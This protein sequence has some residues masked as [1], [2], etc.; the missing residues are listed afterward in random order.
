[1]A[2]VQAGSACLVK[3]GT[4]PRPP[5]PSISRP[6]F[7]VTDQL[8]QC[9]ISAHTPTDPSCLLEGCEKH[10]FW[11]LSL[12]LCQVLAVQQGLIFRRI[13]PASPTS[14]VS[15]TAKGSSLG[16]DWPPPPVYFP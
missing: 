6:Q 3:G 7:S 11:R 8:A 14:P 5:H 1:M 12:P 9:P 13:K 16:Q 4:P 10:Q 2:R 15:H